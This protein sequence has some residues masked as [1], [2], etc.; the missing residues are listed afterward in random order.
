MK[1]SKSSGFWSRAHE[2]QADRKKDGLV[3][4]KNQ[5]Q[6]YKINDPSGKLAEKE[7]VQLEVGWNVQPWVGALTWK[8]PE[9]GRWLGRW[10]ALNGGKSEVFSFPPIK[11]TAKDTAK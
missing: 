5:R 11:G 1:G 6:K 10:A 3:S 2:L 4:L 9:E 8:T 7:G